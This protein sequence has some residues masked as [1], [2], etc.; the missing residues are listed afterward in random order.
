MTH[1]THTTP[2]ARKAHRCQMCYRTISTGETYRRGA[3]MDGSTAWSF[4]ECL[5]CAAFVRVAYARWGD[6]GYDESL[7]IDFD[8]ADIAEARVRAQWRRKWRRQD[9]TLY[10]PPVVTMHQ[11]RFGFGHPVGIKPGEATT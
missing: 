9:G 10:P 11:D 6:E 5:H 7:L 3:G 2:K 1:W 4:I 8:P